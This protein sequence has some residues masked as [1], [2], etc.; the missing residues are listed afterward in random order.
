[1]KTVESMGLLSACG[2]RVARG[3]KK[4]WARIIGGSQVVYVQY[5]PNA[6]LGSI[7]KDQAK[8]NIR[9]FIDINPVPLPVEDPRHSVLKDILELQSF[10][11]VDSIVKTEHTDGGAASI[12]MSLGGSVGSDSLPLIRDSRGAT[13]SQGS[14][15]ERKLKR[16]EGERSWTEFNAWYRKL[17]DEDAK[18]GSTEVMRWCDENGERI[19]GANNQPSRQAIRDHVSGV[20]S[21]NG[22]NSVKAH[23]KKMRSKRS[24]IVEQKADE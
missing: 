24:K 8:H 18:P 1:M 6:K 13:Q 22:P 15:D 14:K 19:W 9:L 12:L 20:R 17:L 5:P 16:R 21:L 11:P 23:F 4:I 2:S 3:I 10:E 7:F